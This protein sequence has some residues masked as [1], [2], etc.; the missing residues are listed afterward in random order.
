MSADPALVSRGELRWTQELPVPLSATR[1]V[2]ATGDLWVVSGTHPGHEDRISQVVGSATDGELLSEVTYRRAVGFPESDRGLSAGVQAGG[3][4]FLVRAWDTRSGQ[5]LWRTPVQAQGPRASVRIAGM[6]GDVVLVRPSIADQGV[7]QLSSLVAL[8]R[9]D[10]RPAWRL[11]SDRG[12]RTV[13][14]GPLIT[15]AYR[16][17]EQRDGPITEVAFVRPGD[18]SIRTEVPWQDYRNHFR[19]AALALSKNRVLLRAD[20]D[21]AG[22][23]HV[24]VVTGD[25]R[26]VWQRPARSEPAVDLDSGIIAIARRDGGVEALRMR[27]GRTVWSWSADKVRSTRAELGRGADGVFWGNS[28]PDN[29]VVDARTGQTLFVG[30]LAAVDPSRWNGRTLVVDG[31]SEVSGY[32]GRGGPIGFRIAQPLTDPLFVA[33][34]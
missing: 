5:R 34:P 28:G 13:T 30:A 20:R 17:D 1:R 31:E 29:I 27:N 4:G 21:N 22:D 11:R 14:P 12:L 18:G 9:A 16:T 24:A 32:T 26:F 2:N 25:G 7:F 8:N 6:A 3:L 19:P 10:G 23:I 33:V 15:V